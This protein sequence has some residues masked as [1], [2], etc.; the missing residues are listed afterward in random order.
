MVSAV[1]PQ[2]FQVTKTTLG[3]DTTLGDNLF[4]KT[5]EGMFP[6]CDCGGG[7]CDAVQE[8]LAKIA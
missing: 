1:D 2:S 7:N 4:L 8:Q 6:P 5:K 3:S